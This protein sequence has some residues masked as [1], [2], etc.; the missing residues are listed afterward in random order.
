M[1]LQ[2]NADQQRQVV[3]NLSTLHRTLEV[4]IAVG[5]LESAV[6]ITKTV[7]SIWSSHCCVDD[8][9]HYLSSI[10][11]APGAAELSDHC[12]VTLYDQYGELTHEQGH[13]E[14]AEGYYRTALARHCN[15]PH[16]ILHL[17]HRI[18]RSAYQRGAHD[19]ARA[20]GTK[21]LEVAQ[22]FDVVE[23]LVDVHR[24]HGYLASVSGNL[25]ESL[26]RLAYA[27]ALSRE[28]GYHDGIAM[29]LCSLGEMERA[30]HN[31]RQAIDYYQASAALFKAY[32]PVGHVVV[33][34]NLAF[35]LLGVNDLTTAE[36]LFTQ[37][38]RYCEARHDPFKGALCLLGLAGVHLAA[39]SYKHAAYLLG[40]ANQRFARSDGILDL[41]DRLAY[42]RIEADLR[43]HVSADELHSIQECVAREGYNAL[44]T[45]QIRTTGTTAAL[46]GVASALSSRE[47]EILRLAAQGLT[48]KQIAGQCRISL[49]TVN[50]HMRGV[51][52]KL[53]VNSRSAA[54]HVAHDQG[55]F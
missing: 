45:G 19:V 9:I 13:F 31:Y 15:D 35:A 8:G 38:V 2:M 6:G 42:E 41:P 7:G 39:H 46:L 21:A 54:V 29:S 47:R 33:N 44:G 53:A 50:N 36:A 1:P 22:R 49:H 37:G 11:D 48:D 55:L 20:Y 24:L 18:G 14:Q 12:L 16:T 43:A 52:R 32:H 3:A 5:D 23:V 28:R 10:L 26:D 34:G 27:H 17:L 25:A 4:L 30:R 51:F 40:L